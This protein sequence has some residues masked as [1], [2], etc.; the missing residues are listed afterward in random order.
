MATLPSNARAGLDRAVAELKSRLDT[1]LDSLVLYGSAVRGDFVQEISDVNLLIVLRESNPASHREI[2]AAVAGNLKIDPMIVG[3]PGMARSFEAFALKFRSM[4][5]DYQVLHGADPFVDFTVRP[6]VE[7]FLCEQALRN[8]RLRLVRGFVILG[9]DRLRYTDFLIHWVPTLFIDLS[10]ALR[11]NGTDIP[12]DFSDRVDILA[13]GFD[14]DTSVLRDLLAL[15]EHPPRPGFDARL[16]WGRRLPRVEIDRFHE[17]T[18]GLLTTAIEWMER[19]W[20]S[21]V[22]F[23][24]GQVGG[25]PSP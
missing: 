10:A 4:A 6:E 9:K 7:R 17:G 18:F 22:T 3:R 1:N 25:E 2:S 19:R 24:D 15:K 13:K 16:V 12:H 5:R 11:L 14:T 8:I 21:D 23:G 20:P